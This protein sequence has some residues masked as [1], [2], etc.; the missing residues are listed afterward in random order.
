MK[1]F[2]YYLCLSD[3][4]NG[5]VFPH[6]LPE[7]Y[8]S[9]GHFILMSIDSNLEEKY[10]FIAVR[11]NKRYKLSLERIDEMDAK[12]NLNYDKLY[13]VYTKEYGPMF[14]LAVLLDKISYVGKEMPFEVETYWEILPLDEVGLENLA[15]KHDFYFVGYANTYDLEEINNEPF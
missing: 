14:F 9:P 2:V 15:K 4:E 11:A 13:V 10:T 1:E 5:L 7:N 8:Y 12:N 6:E 3:K